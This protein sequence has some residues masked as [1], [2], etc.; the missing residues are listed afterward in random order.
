MPD[1]R[2]LS[3][4]ILTNEILEELPLY[5]VS[6]TK[7]LN[8]AGSGTASY[9]L[10]TGVYDDPSLLAATRPGKNA[11]IIERD[12]VPIWGGPIWSR[13]YQSQSKSI[14]LT[15]QTFESIFNQ[16]VLQTSFSA[17]A[18]DQTFI[19]KLILDLMQYQQGNNFFT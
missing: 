17:D 7:Q 9:K 4:D 3:V 8:K 11:L 16:V 12:S 5:G 15:M 10:D 13:T 1:Y 6:A 14:S 19:F 18:W 2:Y